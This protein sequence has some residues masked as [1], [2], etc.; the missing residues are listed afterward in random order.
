[1]PARPDLHVWTSADVALLRKLTREAVPV[2]KIVARLKLTGAQ[3]VYSARSRYGIKSPK[4][5]ALSSPSLPPNDQEVETKT[6][7]D[8]V[9]ARSNGVK[10][11]TVEDLLRHIEADMDRFEIAA[12]EATKW[13]V[14]TKDADDKAVV[15]PAFRVF[16]RLKPKAGPTTEERIA[17]VLDAAFKTRRPPVVRAHVRRRAERMQALVIADPH[18][19]KYSWYRTTGHNYDLDIAKRLLG[20]ATEFLLSHGEREGVTHRFILLLGDVCHYDTPQGTTTAGT[21]LERDGRMQKMIEVG[22]DALIGAIDRSAKAMQTT[23]AL[24][25]GNH[26]RA[27]SWAFQRILQE[28]YRRDDRVTVDGCYTGRKYLTWEG[29]LLGL[30]HGDETSKTLPQ[31]MAIEA[32]EQWGKAA[33]REIHKGHIH[34]RRAELQKPTI[35]TVD[36]VLVRTHPALCPPDDWHVAQGYVGPVRAMETYYYVAGGGL[37]GMKSWSPDA[38]QPRQKRIA[39]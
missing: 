18:F 23:V 15:T 3:C 38:T 25:P 39:A 2:D 29:N 10:I 9:E 32:A 19:G 28:R 21:A 14:V 20:D 17:V 31:L 7:H 35:D 13:E 34:Q 12:S 30:A 24:V 11:K 1:M 26:D 8:G 4:A 16:V 36:G 5:P 27:M 37:D 6:T 22:A 33:Y